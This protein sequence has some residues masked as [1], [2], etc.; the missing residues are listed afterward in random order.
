MA[1]LEI[2]KSGLLDSVQDAGR[3]GYAHLGIPPSGPMDSYSFRL[4]NKLL[5]QSEN[6]PVLEMHFPAATLQFQQDCSIVLT[7]ADFG[8][9]L[10]DDSLPLATVIQVKKGNILKFTQKKFGTRVYLGIKGKWN[11]PSYL[12]SV[13]YDA[14]LVKSGIELFQPTKGSTIDI[15][16]QPAELLS[17]SEKNIVPGAIIR[18]VPNPDYPYSPPTINAKIQAD[19]NRMGYRIESAPIQIHQE[20]HYSRGVQMG[21]IQLLPNGQCLILMAD[22]GTTGGYPILGHVITSDLPYLAQLSPL[23]SFTLLPCSI[24]TAY[25]ARYEMEKRITDILL[26]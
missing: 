1:T 14:S 22:H 16:T 23:S 7:G 17:F 10:N 9:Q 12:Q 4:A 3:N 6:T 24:E 15:D 2:L 5:Q 8:A 11:L 21:S 25:R 13:G 26:N 19:S 18:Y 20:T